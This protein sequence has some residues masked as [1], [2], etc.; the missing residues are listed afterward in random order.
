MSQCDRDPP[1][2]KEDNF[3]LFEDSPL[4]E[5]L[6][7]KNKKPIL[8]S[9]LDIKGLVSLTHKASS[10]IIIDLMIVGVHIDIKFAFGQINVDLPSLLHLFLNG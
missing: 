7:Q 4:A 10:W 5:G 2:G 8:S 1:D 3:H 6:Q 9:F